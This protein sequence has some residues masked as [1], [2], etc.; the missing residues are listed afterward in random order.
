MD[1]RSISNDA[2]IPAGPDHRRLADWYRVVARWQILFDAAIEGLVLKEQ[3]GI[4]V[5]NGRLD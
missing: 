4:A 5:A 2:K 3:H 1:H